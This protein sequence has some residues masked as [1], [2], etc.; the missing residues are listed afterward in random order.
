MD[1]ESSGR[2]RLGGGAGRRSRR[3]AGG[4][5]PR[6]TIAALLLS[7][8]ALACQNQAQ[9]PAPGNPVPVPVEGAPARGAA[10]AWVTIVEFTDFECPYCGREEG[11]LKQILD[12]YPDDV[13]LVVRNFPLPPSMHPFARPAAI[14]AQCAQEQGQ[15]WPMHDL[16]FAHQDALSG[17]DL[18]RYASQAG[19]E[20]AAWQ[21]CRQGSAAAAKVDADVQLGLDLGV[22]ATP[23]FF[24]NGRALDGAYPLDSFRPI[25]DSEIARARSSGIPAAEY[26]DRVVLHK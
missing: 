14:A 6:W 1:G 3:L 26:Y 24:V 7:M 22:N 20:L 17:A 18:E 21:S 4:T 25:I 5:R 10:A 15:Y 19:L 11:V 8:S 16:L 9:Q 13:R 2:E 23:T 12:A